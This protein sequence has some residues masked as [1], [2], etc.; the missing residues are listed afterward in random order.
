MAAQLIDGKQM[1]AEVRAEVAVGV[2]EVKSQ[3]GVT[4]GLAAVLVGDDP[5]SA[6]YV[7]NK[8]IACDE[9]GMFSET[10]QLPASTGQDELLDLVRQ[11]NG[12]TRFHGILVQ[13][14]LPKHI[15]ERAVILALDPNKDVDGL[16]PVNGGRLLE[17]NPRFLPATPAGVQTMLMR[18]GNDPSGKHV[19]IIG[20]SNIVGKP[21]AALLMQKAPGA[22]ATV[23]V[24]HTGTRDIGYFSRQAD[25]VV[26]AV[27]KVNAVTEDMVR[28]GAV[29]IDVGINRVEDATKKSGFR[30]VGDVDFQAVSQKAS[31]IT[32]VPGGVGP[33]TIAILLT[34]TLRAAQYA[35]GDA[36]NA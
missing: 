27:G 31:A 34:N 22:N 5:A 6:V 4:P 1:A 9:A 23:T 11:L 3:K 8:R 14:P 18:S 13:L 24:C 16:H 35:A 26:A 20:R 32:P 36:G 7:R 17:G 33:M 2:A 19:V 21:L 28:E 25:I 12:D 29:V 10:I 30:L 15:D